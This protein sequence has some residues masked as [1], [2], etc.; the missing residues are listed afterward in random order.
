M[1]IKQTYHQPSGTLREPTKR[2]NLL[3]QESRR[4]PFRSAILAAL[5]LSVAASAHANVLSWSGG[6]I[7]GNWS[8]AGNWGFAGVPGNGDSLVFPAP[9]SLVNITNN[10]GGLVLAQIRFAGNG[11]GCELYGNSF[12]LTGGIEA[13]NSIG[14]NVINN[15]ITLGSTNVTVDVGNNAYLTLAGLLQGSGGASKIGLGTLTYAYSGNNTY[16]GTTWVNAGLLQ[17][18]VGGANAF[19]GPLIIGDGSGTGNPIVRLLQSIETPNTQPVTVNLNGLF[20]LNTFSTT[21]GPLTIQG[22]TVSSESGTLSLNGDLTVLGSGVEPMITGNLH[23]NGGMHLV[24]VA[25]GPTFR[26][27]DLFANVSDQG[28]GLLFSNNAPSG[29]FTIL[30]GTNSF[31]GPMIIDNM[32]LSVQTPAGLGT[33]NAGTTVGSHGTLW[34]YSTG[35]TNKTLTLA[36]GATLYGQDN[37][38][39]NGPIVLDGDVIV[40]CY[41]AVSTLTLSGTVSGNGG[42]E[43]VDVGTLRLFGN[44]GN[45]YLGNT[46][47]QNGTCLLDKAVGVA[48]S[49]G[50]LTIGDH[51]GTN[52][53]VRDINVGAN[54]SSSVALAINEGG[55]LD[56]NGENEIVSPIT[57]SGGTIS[58]GT[59]R[60]QINGDVTTLGSSNNAVIDGSILFAGGLRTITVNRGYAPGGYDL[61]IPATIGDNGSGIQFISAAV[62]PYYGQTIVLLTGSNTFTGPLTVNGGTSVL[63]ETPWA[64]GATNS[65]TFVTN[66]GILFVYSTA[67]T[68]ETVTLA[69][70]TTLIGQAGAQNPVWAGPI[71]LAGDATI[72]GFNFFGMFDILGAISGPGNLT[73]TSDGELMRFSG[74]LANT[75]AGTTTVAAGDY[76]FPTPTTLLLN[77]TGVGNSIPGS[78]VINSN[79][80]V[81]NL[82]D[83]QINSPFKPVTIQENGLLDLT[84]HNEWI[85][86]LTLHG[87]Q[88]TTGSGLLYLGGDITCNSSTVAM[89]QITGNASLWN[90][91]RTINC[92]GHNY[93]PDLSITANLS[94]NGASG[95]IKT[96]SGEVTLAGANSTFPGPVTVNAGSLMAK[97]NNALGNTNTPATVTNSGTLALIGN[98]AVGAKP[99]NLAGAVPGALTAGFGHGSWAGNI[100]LSTNVSVDVYTNSTLELSGMITGPGNLTKIDW[101]N[102][103]IDGAISNNFTGGT[104]LQQGTLTLSKTNGPAISG[105]L[106]IGLGLDGANGDVVYTLQ[107]SQFSTSNTVT[108]SSS[109]LL[110]VSAAS[111]YV[112]N[113]GSLTGSGGVQLGNNSLVVG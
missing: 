44:S 91:T 67:I 35:I 23:F 78:L 50:T 100:T 36:A 19:G 82:Q 24:N 10:L 13:T 112:N 88:V 21:T 11:G 70:G 22:A 42:F 31:T 73:V 66:G 76:L 51:S 97:A 56:L 89:S 55:L 83:Y 68:N 111:S 2:M 96:G 80:T 113:V 29:T 98:V 32:T 103:L 1:N 15:S 109:G 81:R 4:G 25:D 72:N 17:L 99:L 53:V 30:G 71:V 45:T 107:K 40:G 46:F 59:G 110:D 60:L 48:I 63:P 3:P 41:P 34:L 20:D 58:T 9:S 28:G 27:L 85:G 104:L 101:G 43:K 5:I 77:R 84:N 38:T 90:G 93:S 86:A 52:A 8:D 102:L 33:T 62:N 106:T 92:I 95:I 74:P 57:L 14:A 18:N 7:S 61:E 49:G 87:A 65:G 79:C 6:G 94:G 37:C 16:S 26:D 75:Y 69:V 12:T 39:W 105:L 64:L 47:I 54:L 108:I